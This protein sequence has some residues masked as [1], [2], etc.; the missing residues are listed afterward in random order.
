[1][2]LPEEEVDAENMGALAAMGDVD[3]AQLGK[4][5]A[6]VAQSI[7]KR[8]NEAQSAYEKTMADRYE[9][10]QARIAQQNSGPSQSEMLFALSRALLSPKES[11]GFKGFVQNM[12][13]A[14]SGISDQERK[15]REARDMQLAQLQDNYMKDTAGFGVKRAQTAAD[16]VKTVAPLL[17]P[18]A[19]STTSPVT[20]G[21]DMKVRSRATGVELKEPPIDAIYALRSYVENPNN[22]PENK[23]IA[24]Q[25]FDKK[26]GYGSS[27]IYGEGE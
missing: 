25:N 11:K 26:F 6:A 7:Y 21:P 24:K 5:P 1:M 13:G 19:K 2:A 16:L 10:A 18:K 12:S 3:F 8:Q 4:D 23:V 17:K 14:F 20:V 15:A 9:A 27:D 22:T